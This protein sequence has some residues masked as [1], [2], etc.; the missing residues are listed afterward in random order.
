MKLSIDLEDVCGNPEDGESLA[1]L[2]RNVIKDEVI[3]YIRKEVKSQMKGKE[4]E[5]RRAV[6]EVANRDWR[7]LAQMMLALDKVKE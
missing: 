6:A 4:A 5:V 1:D 2:L 7:M 3:S